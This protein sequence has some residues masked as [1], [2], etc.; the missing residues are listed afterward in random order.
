[1]FIDIAPVL[2]LLPSN[3]S[4]SLVSVIRLTVTK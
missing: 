4:N 2:Y 1:M 3:P